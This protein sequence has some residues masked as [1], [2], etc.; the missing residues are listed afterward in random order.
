MNMLC[1]DNMNIFILVRLVLLMQ[2]MI[3]YVSSE[4]S[5]TFA[6]IIA[7]TEVAYVLQET[8]NSS[9]LVKPISQ[10]YVDGLS[11]KRR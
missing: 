10:D 4:A 11:I 6:Q 1:F 9:V 8:Y 3:S 7:A 2:L 5:A